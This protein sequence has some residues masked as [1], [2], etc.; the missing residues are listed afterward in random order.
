MFKIIF[1]IYI[2]L[3]DFEMSSKYL[4]LL[5]G[6]IF[7]IVVFVENLFSQSCENWYS[8]EASIQQ[9]LTNKQER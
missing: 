7:V 8:L 6:S 9:I 1:F 3:R 5:F 4:T 2:F